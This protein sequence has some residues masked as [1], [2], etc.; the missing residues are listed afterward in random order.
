M[1]AVIDYGV[2]NLFSLCRSLEAI[3]QEPV[4]TGDPLLL[5][6]ADKLF[7]PGVGAFADA[8]EKLRQS[9]LDEVIRAEVAKGKPLMGICL[10]M[11]LLFDESH[12]F[13]IHKGLGLIPGRVVPME[14][15]IP[16]DLKI[17]HIGWNPL[18]KKGT[19]PL[20]QTVNEGDC[21]YFVHSFFATDC[22]TSVIA[23]TEYGATL[24]AAVAR[25]NVMGCQFH[26][27]KSGTVGLSILKTF[28][29]GSWTVC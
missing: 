1:I 16:S 24:T 2:G 25:G 14:G 8:A 7:L 20:F 10:G 3:G 5:Q 19:H 4:V 29:E 26:P 13:G 21:V 22:D 28:C 6:Q 17:P 12:E 18:L 9:G 23:A 27:E 11:Q 15:V